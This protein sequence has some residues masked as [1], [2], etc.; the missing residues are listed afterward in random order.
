MSRTLVV[1]LVGLLAAGS[2]HFGW[3]ELRRPTELKGTAGVLAWLQQDL[4]LS[5]GQFARIKALHERS[6]PEMRQLTEQAAGMRA[7]LEA[8]ENRRRKDSKIDFLAFAQF[9]EQRREFQR[10]CTESTRRL[11]T[12]AANE[13][14]PGQRERYLERFEPVLG[15]ETG[16][17]N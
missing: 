12:A 17:I 7:E 4:N 6:G 13:M 1:C 10:I 14:T 11:M 5:P 2:A 8:F 15:N 3:Y 16:D 9:I